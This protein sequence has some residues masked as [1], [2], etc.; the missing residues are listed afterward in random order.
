[1][2]ALIPSPIRTGLLSISTATEIA[3]DDEISLLEKPVA[4]G[5]RVYPNQEA[6][7]GGSIGQ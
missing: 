2:C 6:V 4:D 5:N 7:T 1:M 3:F